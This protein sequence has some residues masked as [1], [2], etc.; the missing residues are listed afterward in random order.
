MP[1]RSDRQ[2]E[3]EPHK[4]LYQDKGRPFRLSKAKHFHSSFYTNAQSEKSI[5]VVCNIRLAVPFNECKSLRQLYS[6]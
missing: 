4:G 5:Y 1:R 2:T 3:D 6:A